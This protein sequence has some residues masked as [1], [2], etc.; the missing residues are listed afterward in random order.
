MPI[1]DEASLRFR[2]ATL[3]VDSTV[4]VKVIRGGKEVVVNLTLAA[5]PET[6][7]R[8]RT[9]LDG[10]QPLAGASVVNMSPAMADELNLV[11]WKNGVMVVE[12]KPGAYA[13]RFTRPGDMIVSVNG[14]DVKSVADLKKQI[15]AGVGSITIS[16]D[17]MTNTVQFR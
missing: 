14:Q 15:A 12:I 17:G 16:R 2:L 6:P 11:E 8:E 4:P 3:N 9:L 5:P 10:R 1:D 7:P 13:G